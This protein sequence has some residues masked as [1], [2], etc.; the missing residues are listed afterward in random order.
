MSYTDTNLGGKVESVCIELYDWLQPYLQFNH[1]HITSPVSWCLHIV[2][3]LS[4]AL[5]LFIDFTV[6][7]RMLPK[8][9][10]KA[11]VWHAN[12]QVQRQTLSCW[13]QLWNCKTAFHLGEKYC[14]SLKLILTR[15]WSLIQNNQNSV[16]SSSSLWY[17]EDFFLRFVIENL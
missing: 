14:H 7:S 10:W 12:F 4:V 13:L 8:D 6:R 1:F 17:S 16:Y 2:C 5:L 11:G 3:V 15:L 9:D